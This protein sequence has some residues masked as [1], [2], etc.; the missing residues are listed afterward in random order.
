MKTTFPPCRSSPGARLPLG[1][2]CWG[3]VE[4][5]TATEGWTGA[6]MEETS[7]ISCPRT[8]AGGPALPDVLGHMLTR[9]SLPCWLQHSPAS[10]PR[11]RQSHSY[12]SSRSDEALLAGDDN[13]Q[14]RIKVHNLNAQ[15]LLIYNM[16]TRGE[17]APHS[18]FYSV[19]CSQQSPYKLVKPSVQK[20][21]YKDHA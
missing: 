18:S 2:V 12:E 6:P 21:Q 9:A 20:Y 7:T 15:L 17:S 10:W 8:T 5:G 1:P 19:I 14:A 16:L 11:V 3:L 13:S 4:F